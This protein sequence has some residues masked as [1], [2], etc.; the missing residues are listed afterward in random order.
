MGGFALAPHQ[1]DAKGDF[2]A[3]TRRADAVVEHTV[4]KEETPDELASKDGEGV[5][6]IHKQHLLVDTMI[7]KDE[8]QVTPVQAQKTSEGI[9]HVVVSS[10]TL[11]TIARKYN[12]SIEQLKAWNHLEDHLVKVGQTLLIK[13][14]TEEQ[15]GKEQEEKQDVV[16]SQKKVYPVQPHQPSLQP[17]KNVRRVQESGLASLLT[18]TATTSTFAALHRTVPRGNLIQVY[19]KRNGKSVLVRVVGKLEESHEQELII[20]ISEAAM[21]ILA[22]EEAKFPVEICYIF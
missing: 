15:Q 10:E 20:R 16:E 2:V 17:S 4:A 18:P 9:V 1:T 3:T 22:P 12:V 21:A 7:P 5:E 8:V 11:Y 13:E 14:R 6:E 19:N